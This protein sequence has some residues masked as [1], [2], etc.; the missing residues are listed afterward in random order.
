MAASSNGREV[1]VAFI[2]ACNSR[3]TLREI[4]E[5][6]QNR[7]ISINEMGGKTFALPKS[8]YTIVPD[9]IIN[10]INEA[11]KGVPAETRLATQIG[12]TVFL[13]PRPGPSRMY[14]E[15]DIPAIIV[16]GLEAGP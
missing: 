14:P 6:Q 7:F 13:R 3:T 2:L 10:R 12:E 16:S 1:E 11:R 8:K 5:L 4:L 9:Q 15:T